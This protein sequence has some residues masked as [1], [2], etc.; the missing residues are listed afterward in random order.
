MFLIM[1]HAELSNTEDVKD[2]ELYKNKNSIL[3]D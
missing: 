3:L 1:F 2:G